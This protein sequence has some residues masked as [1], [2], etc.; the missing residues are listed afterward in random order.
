MRHRSP[1]AQA[2]LNGGHL[3]YSMGIGMWIQTLPERG[4]SPPARYTLE[5]SNMSGHGL[6]VLL[7][8]NY[9]YSK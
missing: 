4:A 8:A 3:E 5:C 9:K 6:W 1:E 2:R 7:R